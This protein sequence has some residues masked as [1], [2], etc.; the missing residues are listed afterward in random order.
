MP[1]ETD[2]VERALA[3]AMVDVV[4]QKGL[5]NDEERLKIKAALLK[6]FEGEGKGENEE[7]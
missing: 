3:L 1:K 4:W 7:K 2:V 5:I 6:K